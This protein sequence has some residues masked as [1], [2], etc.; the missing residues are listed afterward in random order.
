MW[1]RHY[2]SD[3]HE[4]GKTIVL[5][6]IPYEVVGVLPQDFSLPREVLPTRG[7]AEQSEIL[8]PLPLGPGAASKRDREDYN[9]IGKLKK[10]LLPRRKQR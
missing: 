4:L 2:G 9:I 10:R 6:G 1:T 8:V 7:G 3:P 5:D